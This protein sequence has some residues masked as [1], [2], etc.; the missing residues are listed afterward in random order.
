MY[1]HELIEELEKHDP[2]KRVRNG[3]QNP[4]SYRGYYDE[5]AFEPCFETTVGAMLKAAKQAVGE[6]YQGWKGGDYTMDKWTPVHL[7]VM[8][9]TGESIGHTLLGYMLAD[10]VREAD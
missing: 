4:H 1:L 2:N 9:A 10:E 5:L 3:F 8:G 6:T 7:A